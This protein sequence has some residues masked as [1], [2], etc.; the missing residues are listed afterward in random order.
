MRG[1]RA[2]QGHTAKEGTLVPAVQDMP[3]QPPAA[4]SHLAPPPDFTIV[5][6]PMGD[7]GNGQA[8]ARFAMVQHSEATHANARTGRPDWT[9][10]L[11]ALREVT[12]DGGEHVYRMMI[13]TSFMARASELVYPIDYT[14]GE[15]GEYVIYT[16]PSEIRDF[17]DS[18]SH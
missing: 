11:S 3:R 16:T 5:A 10:R 9:V 1:K 8:R 13:G 17:V 4:S 6:I 15:H 18:R 2:K 7:R 14:R 12:T